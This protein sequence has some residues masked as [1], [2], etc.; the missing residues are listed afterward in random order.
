MTAGALLS[1][2]EHPPIGFGQ[3]DRQ[4]AAQT[5]GLERFLVDLT[6]PSGRKALQDGYWL[7]AP[8]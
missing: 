2:L 6:I 5:F 1:F 3:P 7:T 4:A 8:S